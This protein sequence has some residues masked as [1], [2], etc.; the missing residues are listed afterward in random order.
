[1]PCLR[2]FSRYRLR[3][4]FALV[5]LAAIALGLWR[6]RPPAIV[7]LDI[8]SNGTVAI[9]REK[10]PLEAI[11]AVLADEMQYRKRWFVSGRIQVAA[12]PDTSY[13]SVRD[14]I[15]AVQRAGFDNLTFRELD[16]AE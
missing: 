12:Q 2:R 9:G 14:V 15:A 5:T 3:T 4:L 8:A 10:V 1:M 13:A 6:L 16:P 7:A 11:P